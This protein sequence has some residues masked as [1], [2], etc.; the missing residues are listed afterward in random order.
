MLLFLLISLTY[1]EYTD[2]VIGNLDK[3]FKLAKGCNQ[4]KVKSNYQR[5][6]INFITESKSKNK[7]QYTDQEKECIEKCST[8]SAICGELNTF[9]SSELIIGACTSSMFLYITSDSTSEITIMA[10]YLE[11]P[12]DKIEENLYTECGSMSYSKCDQCGDDCRL[13][14]CIREEKY[15]SPRA[16]LTNLCL[17]YNVAKYEMWDRCKWYKDVT[18]AQWK[19]EC[20][21]GLEIKSIGA[22]TI[23]FLV[24]IMLAFF[25]FIGVLTWYN[26]KLKKTGTPPIKCHRFCPEILFP[27]PRNIS[28]RSDY[29][30]PDINLQQFK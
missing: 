30:P 28:E 9:D 7:I 4:F 25:G 10:T 20:T 17:P 8:N 15:N 21:E 5:T 27:R 12:C 19:S 3:N 16:V 24:L 11:G 23:I 2:V 22:G 6:K 13:A 1:S 14:E 29:R 26:F 18:L